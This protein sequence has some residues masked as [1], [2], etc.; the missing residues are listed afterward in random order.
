M[1]KTAPNG[2]T[3]SPSFTVFKPYDNKIN[4]TTGNEWH[5]I[6]INITTGN[7]WHCIAIN[8]TTGN[9]W[10]CIAINILSKEEGSPM[11]RVYLTENKRQ[12]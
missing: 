7:E 3:D 6:A 4:I 9:E 8:I 5:C 10:H 2:P 1:I 11:E 12:L